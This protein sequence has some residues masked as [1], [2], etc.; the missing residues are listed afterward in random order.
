MA[1]ATRARTLRSLFSP[2]AGSRPGWWIGFVIV[3]ALLLIGVVIEV[4]PYLYMA[5]GAF[6]TNEEI[7][8]VPLTLWP[9]EWTIENMQELVAGFPIIRWAVNTAI[10]AVVGT[11]LAV[12]LAS[13]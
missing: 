3:N 7:F 6:K 10:V 13:L 12:L 4:V 8:G 11:V 5:F 9:R 2:P 1:I